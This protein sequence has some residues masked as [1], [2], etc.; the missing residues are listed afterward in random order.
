MWID[1]LCICQ[2]NDEEKS[3]QVRLMGEIYKRCAKVCIWVGE[4]AT[5]SSRFDYGNCM[6]WGPTR[7][8]TIKGSRTIMWIGLSNY[9]RNWP[10][11][12]TSKTFLAAIKHGPRK[13]YP[14]YSV[15]S[16]FTM[17]EEI[18]GCPRDCPSEASSFFLR[19]RLPGLEYHCSG[20]K[21]KPSTPHNLLS[22]RVARHESAPKRFLEFISGRVLL[23]LRI[24]DFI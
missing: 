11:T 4:Y 22:R 1:A 5:S 21:T 8:I 13:P 16:G 7:V 12:S 23:S 2:E 3:H 18:M 20:N 10:E 14:M 17:A 24:L 15:L 19:V 6:P 9:R